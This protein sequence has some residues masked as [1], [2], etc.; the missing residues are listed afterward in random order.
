MNKKLQRR[1]EYEIALNF[2]EESHF[3]RI[4]WVLDFAENPSKIGCPIRQKEYWDE[5]K[6]FFENDY[7]AYFEYGFCDLIW[8]EQ[9]EIRIIVLL[10]CIEMTK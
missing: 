4:C 2:I 7:S 5:L 3:N 8:S 9:Q 10:F 6:L 1:K